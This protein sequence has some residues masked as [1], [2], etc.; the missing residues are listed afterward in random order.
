MSLS[1]KGLERARSNNAHLLRLVDGAA[2][3]RLPQL[4]HDGLEAV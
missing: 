2:A 4:V 3:A 1:A